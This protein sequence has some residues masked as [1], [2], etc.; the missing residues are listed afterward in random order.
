MKTTTIVD[1]GERDPYPPP[2]YTGIWIALWPNGLTKF[3]GTY[4]DGKEEG[5]H[6]CYWEN[7]TLA[8]EGRCV[9]GVCIGVW[10]DYWDDK[11]LQKICEYHSKGDFVQTWY[12]SDGSVREIVTCKGGIK[13]KAEQGKPPNGA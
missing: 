9:G 1:D 5:D 13:Q 6:L 8:Q 10:K 11:T 7:G 4:I 3:R 12:D 2:N